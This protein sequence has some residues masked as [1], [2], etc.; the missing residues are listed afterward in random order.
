MMEDDIISNLDYLSWEEIIPLV[1]Y[2]IE[3]NAKFF[4]SVIADQ[5]EVDVVKELTPT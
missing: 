4:R 1:F 5:T 3:I 2:D